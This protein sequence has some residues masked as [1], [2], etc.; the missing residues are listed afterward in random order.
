[1]EA[2]HC[3]D[4]CCARSWKALGVDKYDGK[5][6]PEHIE[7]LKTENQRLKEFARSV[8]RVECWGYDTPDG[9]DIQDIAIRLNLI[10]PHTATEADVNE[11]TDYEVGDTIYKFA[12]ILAAPPQKG[13]DDESDQI[14]RPD[15]DT[16][17]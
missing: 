15:L 12:D 5:S 9:G 11:F 3:H 4:C 14:P 16:V 7:Q 8:I 13:Q 2:T 6:I 17:G 10:E 1:M